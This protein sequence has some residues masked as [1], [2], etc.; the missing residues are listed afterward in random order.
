MDNRVAQTNAFGLNLQLRHG[1]PQWLRPAIQGSL[2]R[3]FRLPRLHRGY[4]EMVAQENNSHLIDRALVWLNI[5][6]DLLSQALSL[7]RADASSSPTTRS[8]RSKG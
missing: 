5:G 3:L 7:H 8:A 1:L 6:Y 4:S 2:E